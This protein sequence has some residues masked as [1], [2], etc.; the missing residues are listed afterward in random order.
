VT[1]R[2]K[3][4][5]VT[6]AAGGLGRQLVQEYRAKGARVLAWDI[7]PA[8]VELEESLSGVRSLCIDITAPG[9]V[10]AAVGEV[11]G[12]IDILCNNAGILD[13]LAL[14]EET[15]DEQ[16]QACLAVNLTAP[17]LLCRQIVPAMVAHGGGLVV[18]IASVG[19]IRG[20]RAGAA[21][22]ASK[23]GLVGLTSNIAAT[24]AAQ[25]I[26]CIAVCP[27]AMRTPIADGMN[28]S[29]LG[30]AFAAT[31]APID[32]V[33]EPEEVARVVVTLSGEECAW[34]NGAVIPVDGGWSA[35]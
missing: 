24:Y 25:S 23:F 14:V 19:G 30:T 29:P 7:D 15:S 10:R 31:Q 8:V 1:L 13:A 11:D 27:G 35:Y 4:A 6:G 18:N 9:G 32:R 2:G 3:T 28:L 22:T 26:R 34:V 16:W 17:F 20:G 5:L 21:Y 33:A 12:R